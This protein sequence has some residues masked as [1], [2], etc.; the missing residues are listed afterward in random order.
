MIS[1][2]QLKALG[3]PGKSRSKLLPDV[4]TMIEQGFPGDPGDAW[5]GIMT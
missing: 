2:G 5:V 3:A 4:P 1:A